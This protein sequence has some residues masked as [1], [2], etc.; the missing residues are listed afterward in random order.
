MNEE[1][2][3]RVDFLLEEALSQSEAERT[4]FLAR[5]FLDDEEV[6]SEVLSLVRCHERAG[7]FL[8]T[9]SPESRPPN[10]EIGRATFAPGELLLERFHIVKMR[11]CGGMGEV[12][13]AV[14][15]KLQERIALKTIRPELAWDQ[16]ASERFLREVHL[17]RMVTH[18]NVCRIHDV[19][20]DSQEGS[21][22]TLF[23]TME[24]LSGENLAS[25]LERRGRIDWREAIPLLIQ[26]LSGLEAAFS[27]GVLHRDLKPENVMLVPDAS[28]LRAVLTDFG[29][30]VVADADQARRNVED[31]RGPSRMS[32]RSA[33]GTPAYMSPEQLRGQA[34]DHRS[35]LFSFG[36]IAYEA[37]S[38]AHPF[39]IESE[40][41]LLGKRFETK[42]R[43]LR[44]SNRKIP[45]DLDRL[46]LQLLEVEPSDRPK[47]ASELRRNL[48]EIPTEI[49]ARRVVLLT[50][51]SA[52]GGAFVLVK[53]GPPV[54]E[55]LE[56]WI[57]GPR[58]LPLEYYVN[59]PK[60]LDA[61]RTGIAK[62][63]EGANIEA[64][65]YFERAV[66][67]DTDSM[68]AH[69]ELIETLLDI[70]E[71]NRAREVLRS[72]SEVDGKPQGNATDSHLL[73]SVRARL[74]EDYA[75]SS[76]ELG[77][78]VDKYRDDIHLWLRQA[79][80]L[81]ETGQFAQVL[82]LYE[83]VATESV[84]ALLG[85]GR[86]L[87]ATGQPERAIELVASKALSESLSHEAMGMA[88]SVLGMAHKDLGELPA[89]IQYLTLSLNH[90]EKA[91]DHRGQAA[92]LTNL[93]SA[94]SGMGSFDQ[95]ST[96]LDRA[97][98]LSR[99]MGDRE[100]ESYVIGWMGSV[101]L[102]RGDPRAAL[103]S[104]RE[105]LA[106]DSAR[107]DHGLLAARLNGLALAN[108]LLGFLD[109]GLMYLAEA[110]K[111][112]EASG[113]MDQRASAFY[114]KGV[115]EAARGQYEDS[116]GAF[117]RAVALYRQAMM[118]HHVA[119]VKGFLAE[120]QRVRGA[121]QA[122]ERTLLEASYIFQ[123]L[124]DNLALARNELREASLGVS[125][126]AF[127]DA[128]SALARAKSHLNGSPY[129]ETAARMLIV[130]GELS[131]ARSSFPSAVEELRLAATVS[132]Q[133]GFKELEVL[134][135]IILGE[136]LTSLG[137]LSEAK[138]TLD[139]ALG[140]ARTLG[141]RC[142]QTMATLGLSH[143]HYESGNFESAVMTSADAIALAKLMSL[144]P[145]LFRG[146]V[147][148]GNALFRLGRSQKAREAYREAFEVH[149]ALLANIV[150]PRRATYL[151]S[152]EIRQRLA[153]MHEFFS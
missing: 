48:G 141:F 147:A 104:F 106:I 90:R 143:L 23:L 13:E 43:S 65:A 149:Q 133:S 87:T 129:W 146:S 58:V 89:A 62:V 124:G 73:H 39:P 114:L 24:L 59:S 113:Q 1:T 142:L 66:E 127:P 101:H 96:F 28:T 74:D 144:R 110:D 14:D 63:L 20:Q 123:S 137:E 42:P 136:A 140:I 68:L 16:R 34:V 45:R 5:I 36:V 91:R 22:S 95:S 107:E 21:E 99:E 115:I 79:R 8:S 40:T 100:Y 132:A 103:S 7:S 120:T 29:L 77:V 130:R 37:L 44:V 153:R 12:Y 18:R 126:G 138:M 112:I 150:P 6:G 55:L 134:A 25:H 151:D 33:L 10:V 94:Y 70:G 53:A 31:Q 38:G 116:D 35:D 125:Q 49:P 82:P 57:G 152:P 54:V 78:V 56:T 97:L 108:A 86:A 3:A 32:S 135:G 85:L 27:V 75:S 2:R 145:I 131:F 83:A 111:H 30:A 139:T 148:L 80:R 92:S 67:E 93:A 4:A 41:G 119:K 84:A 121:F 19:F 71:R 46:V 60:A 47:D 51:A 72:L 50:A 98:R 64:I 61:L 11:A 88:H 17:A 9:P 26:I 117:H 69:V 52:V 15:Q 102:R 122:A 105:T 128:E 118:P 81:E 76:H 109:D